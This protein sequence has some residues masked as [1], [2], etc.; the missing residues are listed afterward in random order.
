M[1]IA[2]VTDTYEGGISGGAVTGV[3]FVEALRRRHEVTVLATGAPAPG[4]VCLPGFQVP[5]RAMRENRYTFGWPSRHILEPVF[6]SVDLVHVQ[7]PFYLGFRAVKLA[8]RMGVPLVAAFHV[9]P[10]NLLYNV[11]LHS[12]R[13]AA[14]LHRWWIRHVFE[15]AD[16]VV[17]PSRFA[18]ERLQQY[19]LT[20]PTWVISNG[21]HVLPR[22]RAA[23]RERGVPPYVLLCVG[24]L[25]PEKRQDVIIDAVARCRHRDQVRLV[26][27]GAGSL[28]KSLRA[29]AKK[30]GLPVEFGYVSDE[31]LAQLYDEATLFVHAGEVELEGMAV[32]DAMAAGL[33]VLV[34]DAPD[35]AS[36]AFASGPEFRFR[37]GDVNDLA[38][39]IDALLDNPTLLATGARRSLERAAQHD[40]QRSARSL[41]NLYEAVLAKA[42]PSAPRSRRGAA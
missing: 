14:W 41:E 34:A 39:R 11:H 16:A 24:R 4:K 35:S 7:F 5:I 31:R 40:F 1:R 12:P 36:R 42:R 8:R 23:R 17:V 22:P 2:F 3:R 29:R 10:E 28:E 13:I 26:V 19:G 30:R 37:P 20:T 25:A 33:P 38:A 6:A 21:A 32:I 9:Q 27:V 18:A 15:P